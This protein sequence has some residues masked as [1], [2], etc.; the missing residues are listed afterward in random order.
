M[1]TFSC[2][3]VFEHHLFCISFK[4][5]WKKWHYDLNQFSNFFYYQIFYD[6]KISFAQYF[7]KS[8]VQ[9]NKFLLG[10][11]LIYTKYSEHI[12][13]VSDSST[14]SQGIQTRRRT[15]SLIPS[16]LLLCMKRHL[17]NGWVGNLVF[18]FIES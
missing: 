14:L 7:C 2:L 17:F 6:E 10:I 1:F 3:L 12:S 8:S 18:Q 16:L 5:F 13:L 4:G 15:I 11:T 9:F